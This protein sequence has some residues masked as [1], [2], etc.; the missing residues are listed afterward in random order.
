MQLL[1]NTWIESFEQKRSP[2]WTF[3]GDISS[4]MLK[5]RERERAHGC[6]W[7]GTFK[8]RERERDRKIK[9]KREIKGKKG[10]N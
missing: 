3:I 5:E 6:M 4:C 1:N 8:Q 10:V 2:K 7:P 9:R